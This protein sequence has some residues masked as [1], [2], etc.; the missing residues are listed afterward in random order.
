MQTNSHDDKSEPLDQADHDHQSRQQPLVRDAL[1]PFEDALIAQLPTLEQIIE[2][3]EKRQ[4]K[5]KRR[6][7]GTAFAILASTLATAFW[8][9]PAYHTTTQVTAIGQQREWK[10]ADGSQIQL[11]TDSK[12][13]V[14]MHLRS[15]RIT[16]HQGEAT[17][18]VAHSLWHQILPRFERPFTVQAGDLQIRDI[19]TVFNVRLTPQHDTHVTVLEGRVLVSETHGDAA[20]QIELG[21]GQAIY[22]QDS[23]LQQ[24]IQVDPEQTTAWRQGR[25]YFYNQTLA[26]VMTELNRY[27]QLPVVIRDRKTEQLRI[28]AQVDI[29]QR[30]QFI[31]LLPGFVPVTIRQDKDGMQTIQL[32]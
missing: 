20:K 22:S 18:H 14:A 5:N 30:E 6:Q 26:E 12:I 16:L 7:K 10:L 21:A 19:G 1:A 29:N 15:R 3:A 32:K 11:N 2:R 31:A 13:T 9:D 24:I 4:Q 27:G 28:T 17:F 25:I 8:L 23:V